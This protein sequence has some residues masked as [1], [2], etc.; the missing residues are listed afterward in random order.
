MRVLVVADDSA[1][2]RWFV[3]TTLQGRFD[4]VLEARDGG[5]LL[6]NVLACVHAHPACEVTV[7][8]DNRMPS[9]SGLDVIDAYDELGYHPTTIVMTAYPDAVTRAETRRAGGWLIAKPFTTTEL[10]EVVELAAH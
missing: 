7:V 3:R 10:R 6:A 9:Y 5:E 4:E 2:M 8:T 1:E